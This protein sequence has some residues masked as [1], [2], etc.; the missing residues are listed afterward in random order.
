[1]FAKNKYPRWNPREYG[2]DPTQDD[3]PPDAPAAG[4]IRAAIALVSLLLIVGVG[5]GSFAYV[6]SSRQAA[7]LQLAATNEY[8]SQLATSFVDETVTPTST[9][10][11][12][13]TPISPGQM[14]L[15]AIASITP[16]MT[17]T[18][19]GTPTITQTATITSTA[20]PAPPRRVTRQATRQN[21]QSQQSA[22]PERIVITSP[23][24]IIEITQ[25]VTVP[26][27]I[28][29]TPSATKENPPLPDAIPIFPDTTP[30]LIPSATVSN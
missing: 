17:P 1:M 21:Q 11:P 16:S 7:D 4:C 6:Q 28:T 12:T 8:L 10:S 14:T 30:T 19:T 5:A 18:A 13:S 25:I 24:Q 20:S 22:P 26:E 9:P 15:T 3:I 23:P 27:I 2:E 29:A